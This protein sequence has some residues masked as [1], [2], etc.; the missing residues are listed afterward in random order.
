MSGYYYYYYYSMN[1]AKHR[2]LLADTG[3]Y[4]NVSQPLLLL[5]LF[6]TQTAFLAILMRQ[7][8]NKETVIVGLAFEMIQLFLIGF[9]SQHT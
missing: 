8:G 7:F 9:S 4:L 5:L 2:N 3:M 1:F 6:M